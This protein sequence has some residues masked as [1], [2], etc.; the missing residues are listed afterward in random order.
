MAHCRTSA[1][2]QINDV[3]IQWPKINDDDL[4][5]CP[6]RVQIRA[7]PEYSSRQMCPSNCATREILPQ[8]T[9]LTAH[10]AHAD[11]STCGLRSMTKATRHRTLPLRAASPSPFLLAPNDLHVSCRFSSWCMDYERK[12]R[13]IDFWG[14]PYRV[15]GGIL[16]QSTGGK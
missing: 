8:Q 5:L 16:V 4:P 3:I 2:S 15:Q 1:P 12:H 10:S 9:D 13:I 14:F 6:D 11:G 7:V